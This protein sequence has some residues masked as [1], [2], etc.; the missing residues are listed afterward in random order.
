MKALIQKL[1][2]TIAPS[3]YEMPIRELILGE[4]KEVADEVRVDALGNLVVRKGQK[5]PDGKRI[6]LAAHMDEIGLI[7]THIDENGFVRFST[8]GGVR[9]HTLYGGRVRFLNGVAGVIGGERLENMDRVHGFEKLFIDVG[10]T[11]QED[12]PVRV[13]DV[14][15]FERPFLDL[16]KRLVAKSMDDRISVAVMIETLR[17]LKDTPHEVFFVFTTQEEVGVRGA[18]TA[19]FGVDPEIGIAVD[20]TATGDTPRGMKMAVALGKGPAIKVKDTGMIADPRVVRWMADTAE[21]AG[22]PYQLEILEGGSTDA[23][24]MQLTRAGVPAG[25]LSIPCRYIHTP[26]E[27]VDFEDVQNAVRMLMALLQAPVDLK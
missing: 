2:E 19:A 16:G 10:A 4:V 6:M 17:Q 8:I 27:M 7:A 18:T 15:A 14:A 13:G 3:G 23:R 21:Q 26:S 20:V 5:S 11:S 25:C 24:A 12:C 22:I 9:P 1:V